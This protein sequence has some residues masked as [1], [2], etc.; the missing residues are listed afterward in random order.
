MVRALAIGATMLAAPAAWSGQYPAWGDTGWVYA[1]KRE[2]CNAAI[3]IAQEH[4]AVAC[5]NAGGTLR[6]QSS[7][8]RRRGS[9]KWE[10]NRDPN[11]VLVYRCRAEATAPC[12]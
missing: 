9:C 5:V 12:R 4:S 11:G 10:S 3:A 6:P 2:C 8:V 1:S 7:G